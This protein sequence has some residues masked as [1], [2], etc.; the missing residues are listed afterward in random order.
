[1]I[2]PFI[3]TKLYI[4]RLRPEIISRLRLVERINQGL[5]RK[6]TLVSAPAGFG[7]TTLLCEWT[8]ICERPVAWV[9]LDKS[10]NDPIRFWSYLIAAVRTIIPRFG[11]APLAALKSSQYI[12]RDVFLSGFIGEISEISTPFAVVLDDYHLIESP[13]IH[14][15]IAS[16][17]DY[18][19]PQMH[20]VI[21]TR[22]DPPVPIS[23]LRGRDGLNELRTAD[24][25]FNI[26]ETGAFISR[27]MGLDLREEDI[28]TLDRHTEG[29]IVGLQLAAL[30]MRG[31]SDRHAYIVNLAGDNRYIA[32]YLIEEVLLGQ[33]LEVQGFL[34]QTSILDYLN[35]DLCQAVTGLDNCHQ[36][37]IE[38]DQN[39]LF[40]N[41]MDNYREWYRYHPLFADLLKV[42]LNQ[43]RTVEVRV[44]HQ[45][46]SR[47]FEDHDLPLEAVT[48]A[49]AVG[50]LNRAT[51]LIEKN[52]M[53]MVSHGEIETL[54][55]W[56]D[57]LPIEYFRTHPWLNVA[58]AWSYMSA[59]QLN[60]AET[61][62]Q[63][64]EIMPSKLTEDERLSGHTA[65]IRAGIAAS[66]W[67]QDT[68][69]VYSQQAL[70]NL[71]EEDY[72]ARG[73][74]ATLHGLALR[75]SGDL[76]AAVK[77]YAEAEQIGRNAGDSFT[78]VLA[79]CYKGYALVLSG[80][81]K[82]AHDTLREAIRYAEKSVGKGGWKPPIAGLAHSFLSGVYIE[83]NDLDAAYHHAH[84]GLLLSEKWGQAHAI[85]DGYFF[86]VNTCVALRDYSAA[87]QA[88]QK[89]KEFAAGVS[90]RIGLDIGR[91]EIQLNLAGGDIIQAVK[92]IEDL[93]IK[94]DD[95]IAFMELQDY[96]NLARV[97][98][99]KGE[100]E[101][102]IVLMDR[103]LKTAEDAGAVGQVV[104][105][106][107]AQALALDH[108]GKKL[109]AMDKIA[110]A[111]NAAENEGFVRTFIQ[112]GE[113]IGELLRFAAVQGTCIE[114]VGRLLV[115]LEEE[116]ERIRALKISSTSRLIEPLTEREE[117]VLRLLVLGLSST[118]IAKELM[119]AVGTA[120]THIK[121]IYRKLSVHRRLEA[122]E[123]A[124][125]LKL[126]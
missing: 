19:P 15:S 108:Q 64:L 71:P 48:H 24:L 41:P 58:R 25:R 89:V 12:S 33:S 121:S 97:L 82:D 116:I 62:L 123:R 35:G 91:L 3:P 115:A 26:E 56:L 10:D 86:Y 100:A 8:G 53:D 104:E 101:E 9:T 7:K 2:A 109:Q 45:R 5:Y 43:A 11:E 72:M 23:R 69:L 61:Q 54:I 66:T 125:E 22:S 99:V 107:V 103:L 102:A 122:I 76:P 16:L 119:I 70:E 59:G 36:I 68:T 28:E 44:L 46:A 55:T 74:A 21:A 120:R 37:L 38:L 73:F 90:S 27:S 18:S 30:S 20:L 94:A 77:A 34:L 29:W 78:A 63:G 14:E 49:F 112:E 67:D 124:K 32:D 117:Q 1:M 95:S 118:E 113:P 84:T 42:R 81:L 80:R 31:Q 110:Q 52:S 50:D 92:Q 39:N 65:A 111:L 17:L 51:A 4:P 40:I 85:L 105:I 114:Y 13:E 57:M 88:L 126:V 75:W 60:D 96:L 98:R 79:S 83:W 87:R 47:W 6:L 106:L 93:E